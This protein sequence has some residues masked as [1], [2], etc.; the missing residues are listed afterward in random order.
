MFVV[1]LT[2]AETCAAQDFWIMTENAGDYKHDWYIQTDSITE[3]FDNREFF[4]VLKLVLNDER[5]TNYPQIFRFVDGCWYAKQGNSTADFIPVNSHELYWR[6][7]D[8]CIGYCKL[9]QTYPR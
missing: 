8:A 5:V 6:A 2:L 4:V 9:A 1:T 3:E 7:F